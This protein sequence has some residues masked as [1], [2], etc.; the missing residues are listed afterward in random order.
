[1]GK[2]TIDNNKNSK[3]VLSRRFF[4]F[5]F[6]AGFFGT[7]LIEALLMRGEK[8]IRVFDIDKKS[9]WRNDKRVEF[10]LGDITNYDE[11]ES[12]CK[13][14]DVVFLNAAAITF[15]DSLDYQYE[16]SYQV[17]V[18][19]TQNVIRACKMNNVKSLL[20]TSSPHAVLSKF[21]TREPTLLNETTPYVN[22]INA[23]SHYGSTKA[24]AEQLT[25]QAN[26]TNGL[27]TVSI[28]PF[29]SIFG[30]QDKFLLDQMFGDKLIISFA[31]DTY[32]DWIFVD[33]AVY[34]HLLAERQLNLNSPI[35]GQVF[36][37]SNNEPMYGITFHSIV[38]YYNKHIRHVYG[39]SNLFWLICFSIEWLQNFFGPSMP[40]L[41]AKIQ[42]LTY[43]CW[44][45][46]NINYI[47]SGTNKAQRLL[48]YTP[49]FT[50]AEAI[51][52]SSIEYKN[53]LNYIYTHHD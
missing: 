16:R 11:C 51:Q 40:T 39:P 23:T 28:R 50:T 35:D 18:V 20:Q 42:C 24:K 4:C 6:R 10:I 52:I 46:V 5:F 33:N 30:K 21:K 49:V 32:I 41:P 3:L 29:S 17:N 9:E 36:C 45:L 1:L 12:A 27:R 26:D 25:L 14:I 19:G 47:L 15:M 44:K 31:I 8:K 37:V 2:F 34:A 22:E 53:N 7:R 13:G 38:L 43:T 48:D